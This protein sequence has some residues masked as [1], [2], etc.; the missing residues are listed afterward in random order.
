MGSGQER[1]QTM[2]GALKYYPY[3]NPAP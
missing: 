1:E 2:E 3:G